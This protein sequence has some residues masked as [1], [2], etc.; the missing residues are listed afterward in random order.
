MD[1]PSGLTYR[2][3]SSPQGEIAEAVSTAERKMPE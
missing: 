2:P 1:F 3:G